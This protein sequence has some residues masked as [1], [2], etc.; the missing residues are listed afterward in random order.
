MTS[1][2]ALLD[3]NGR[4][5]ELARFHGDAPPQLFVGGD[6]VFKP[7]LYDAYTDG[8]FRDVS[9]NEAREFIAKSESITVKSAI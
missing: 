7:S 8:Y 3:K 4:I 1:Y 5:E 6:W 2:F 9:E